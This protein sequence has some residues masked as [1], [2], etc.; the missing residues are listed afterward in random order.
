MF[1]MCL[2]GTESDLPL[3]HSLHPRL[4][5][6]PVFLSNETMLGR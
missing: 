6:L 5:S 1:P 2:E 3:G 4:V